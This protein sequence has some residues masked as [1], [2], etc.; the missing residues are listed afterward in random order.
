MRSVLKWVAIV[1][2]CAAVV[3]VAMYVSLYVALKFFVGNC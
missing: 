1:L 3:A 2:A